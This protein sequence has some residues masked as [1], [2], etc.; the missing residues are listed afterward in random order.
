MADRQVLEL[1][2]ERGVLRCARRIGRFAYCRPNAP[3]QRTAHLVLAWAVQH[4]RM[5]LD[6]R[7][8]GVMWMRIGDGHD[9]GAG[10]QRWITPIVARVRVGQDGDVAATQSKTGV[11]KP[12]GLHFLSLPVRNRVLCSC[13]CKGWY[14]PPRHH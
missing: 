6:G 11:A 4:A 10:S 5:T 1:Q 9:V 14:K 2:N 12:A 3:D 13:C 7:P 8:G